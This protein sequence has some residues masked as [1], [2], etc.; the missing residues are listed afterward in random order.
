M[1]SAVGVGV[2]GLGGD[3]AHVVLVPGDPDVAL[4]PPARA[5]AV[6]HQPVVNSAL[7]KPIIAVS[8]IEH[9]Y[10]FNVSLLKLL[11]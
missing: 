4:L 3:A 10:S 5:P 2:A 6:L 7:N 9:I 11:E 8:N 1:I